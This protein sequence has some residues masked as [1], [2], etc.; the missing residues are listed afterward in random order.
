LV[1]D[2]KPEGIEGGDTG[3]EA[4]EVED[5]Q[6]PEQQDGELADD[7]LKVPTTDKP[8]KDI[9]GDNTSSEAVSLKDVQTEDA[10]INGDVGEGDNSACEDAEADGDV[11]GEAEEEEEEESVTEAEATYED[12][13]DEVVEKEE[14]IE[15]LLILSKEDNV[16]L[17]EEGYK[18]RYY[19][20]KLGVELSDK[21]FIHKFVKHYVEGLCWVL[22]YYYQ[23]CPSWKWYYPYHYSP[24]ASDFEGLAS[25]DIKFELGEPFKPFE[26]L[27]GVL[28]ADSK[29][30]LPKAFWPLMTDA[31]SPI[32]DFYPREFQIDL[33]GKK[34]A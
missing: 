8:L 33:N 22:Q 28:P 16:R 30:N 7:T 34:H 12:D 4:T 13:E 3:S 20:E 9:E 6:Q 21:E 2:E 10:E 19:R 23:G 17:W 24:F 31:D 32:I 25:M 14:K 1:T 27:M 11:R 18:E 26:Q 29:E 15:E 5:E